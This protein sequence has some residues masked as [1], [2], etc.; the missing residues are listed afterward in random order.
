MGAALTDNVEEKTSEELR[1]QIEIKNLQASVEST[2]VELAGLNTTYNKA[3]ESIQILNGKIESS[4]I[5]ISSLEVEVGKLTAENHAAME[6]L[7]FERQ[8]NLEKTAENASLESQLEK[9]NE[10]LENMKVL[11]ESSNNEKRLLQAKIEEMAD[12]KNIMAK[13]LDLKESDILEYNSKLAALTENVEEKTS[14]ELRL[15]I[16]TKN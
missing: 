13:E 8:Q 4:N 5:K 16:E 7:N 9:K 3:K 1:L 15:Q 12:E 2:E 11:M 14:E 6:E 10:Y